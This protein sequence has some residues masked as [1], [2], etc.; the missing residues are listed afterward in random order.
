MLSMKQRSVFRKCT[1]F[2][3]SVISIFMLSPIATVFGQN[4]LRRITGTVTNTASQP[5][6]GATVTV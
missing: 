1:L 5:V 2:A 6:V 3:W 4:G